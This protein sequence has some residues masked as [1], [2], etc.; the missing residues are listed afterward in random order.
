LAA[1]YGITSI[2]SLKVFQDG[3]V[4]D[5]QVGLASKARLQAMLGK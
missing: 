4:V 1:R 5:E 2:P 3:K